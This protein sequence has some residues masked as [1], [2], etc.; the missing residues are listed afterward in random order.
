MTNG[1]IYHIRWRRWRV[2]FYCC[3]CIIVFVKITHFCFLYPLQRLIVKQS[4]VVCHLRKK[5]YIIAFVI[6][7]IFHKKKFTP[8][9]YFHFFYKKFYVMIKT[10]SL[11]IHLLIR[12]MHG[13]HL[14][15]IVKTK[16]QGYIV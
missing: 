5:N 1:F 7:G 11:P 4:V 12:I 14:R 16:C 9:S 2:S 8:R 3:A 6:L 15:M 13:V 10:K